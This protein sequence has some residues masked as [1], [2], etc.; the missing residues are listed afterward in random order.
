VGE[1][2]QTIVASKPDERIEIRLDFKRPMEATSDVEFLFKPE[3]DK[4]NVTWNMRGKKD[5]VSKIFCL[6]MNMDKMVGG[7][8]EKGLASLKQVVESPAEPATANREPASQEPAPGDG[9][10]RTEETKTTEK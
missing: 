5:F 2:V 7:D 6:F 1:G 9:S 8:F 4:T 3:G 10:A